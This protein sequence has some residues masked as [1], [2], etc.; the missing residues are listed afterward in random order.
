MLSSKTIEELH[1]AFESLEKNYCDYYFDFVSGEKLL[2]LGQI[3]LN[4][5]QFLVEE[6][7]QPLAKDKKYFF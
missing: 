6:G 1:Q 3:L 4:L 2:L 5:Q 7:A